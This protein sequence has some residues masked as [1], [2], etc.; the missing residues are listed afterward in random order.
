MKDLNQTK[1]QANLLAAF[2]AECM[3][4]TKYDFYA[5][6]AKKEGFEHIYR[7]FKTIADNERAHAYVWYRLL[8]NAVGTTAQNLAEASDG[9]YTEW[10]QMYKGF[11]AEAKEEGFDEIAA[12]FEKTADVEQEHEQIYRKL[13]ENLDNGKTFK[14]AESVMWICLNCGHVHFGPSAPAV[15]PLCSHPQAFFTVKQ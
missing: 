7:T 1:T 14:R 2:A 8:K 3:A 4:R 12:K 6:K 11:A 9:E 13:A 15:C 10:S 5:E